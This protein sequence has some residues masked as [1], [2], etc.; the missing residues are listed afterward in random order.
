MNHSHNRTNRRM[1]IVV[2]SDYVTDVIGASS[3]PKDLRTYDVFMSFIDSDFD[4]QIDSAETEKLFAG[5]EDRNGF[6]ESIKVIY[7]EALADLGDIGK[8][9]NESNCGEYCGGIIPLDSPLS[10]SESRKEKVLKQIAS[11]LGQIA[12]HSKLG[13]ITPGHMFDVVERVRSEI[14]CDYGLYP[15]LSNHACD[16]FSASKDIKKLYSEL[17]IPV[18]SVSLWSLY[19]EAIKHFSYQKLKSIYPEDKTLAKN[20]HYFSFWLRELA[21]LPIRNE[22]LRFVR[23]YLSYSDVFKGDADKYISAKSLLYAQALLLHSKNID[24]I[25]CG[26]N[27]IDTDNSKRL[28]W[29]CGNENGKRGNYLKV[30]A[31]ICFDLLTDKWTNHAFMV[32]LSR[33]DNVYLNYKIACARCEKHLILIGVGINHKDR[34]FAP[35]VMK[36]IMGKA[37]FNMH[38]DSFIEVRTADVPAESGFK[39]LGAAEFKCFTYTSNKDDTS[40]L[41]ELFRSNLKYNENDVRLKMDAINLDNLTMI[42]CDPY[43]EDHINNHFVEVLPFDEKEEKSIRAN[44]RLSEDDKKYLKLRG[45]Q[46]DRLEYR[47]REELRRLSGDIKQK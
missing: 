31:T 3:V 46:L 24:L 2:N 8:K 42:L 21:R 19:I 34:Q 17:K 33:S 39:P 44:D 35:G 25:Y 4:Y 11:W 40:Y 43:S 6:L 41:D 38:V 27:I 23:S 26:Y 14:F 32:D 5:E 29:F 9:E 47:N 30:L 7:E 1:Q 22:V 15:F 13:D 10:W 45:Q 12:P 20:P 36:E 37:G 18:D 28:S 16:I